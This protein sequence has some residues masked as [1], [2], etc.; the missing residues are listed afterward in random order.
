[1]WVHKMCGLHVLEGESS[2]WKL[3]M[4]ESL[5]AKPINT[6]ALVKVPFWVSALPVLA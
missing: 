5:A 3:D 4:L 6:V 2:T 1:M